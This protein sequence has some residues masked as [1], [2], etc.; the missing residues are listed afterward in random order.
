MSEDCQTCGTA[1]YE[2]DVEDRNGPGCSHYN[3]YSEGGYTSCGACNGY[4][5]D[6]CMPQ[7]YLRKND[8]R[9]TTTKLC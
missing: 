1:M 2:L 6:R 3:D 8:A 4:G 5:C 7:D 9:Y